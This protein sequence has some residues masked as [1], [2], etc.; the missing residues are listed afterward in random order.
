MKPTSLRP[1]ISMPQVAG[2]GIC[3]TIARVTLWALAQYAAPGRP[4]G[5][6]VTEDSV[7]VEMK[8][9]KFSTVVLY[10]LTDSH[11][12]IAVEMDRSRQLGSCLQ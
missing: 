11:D 5:R 3:D 8:P 10:R 4:S 6:R 12:S 2:S 9:R 1:A 7:L